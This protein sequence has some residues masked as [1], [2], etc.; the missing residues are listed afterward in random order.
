VYL[1]EKKTYYGFNDVVAARVLG[2][3]EEQTTA[4]KTFLLVR[5]PI[6]SYNK[7]RLGAAPHVTRKL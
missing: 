5:L 2:F 1:V 3:G 7:R 6:P 4:N